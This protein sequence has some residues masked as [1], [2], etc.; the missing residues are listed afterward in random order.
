MSAPTYVGHGTIISQTGNA[1]NISVPVPSGYQQNDLLILTVETYDENVSTPSGWTLG[2]YVSYASQTRITLFYKWSAS[3]ESSVVVT[4]NMTDHVIGAMF[5]FRGVDTTSPFNA[6]QSSTANVSQYTN[7]TVQMP[8]STINDCLFAVFSSGSYD[9]ASDQSAFFTSI[10]ST[11]NLTNFTSSW[12][13]WRDKGNGGGLGISTGNLATA[14]S[15]GTL[16]VQRTLSEKI[17]NF[18]VALTPIS[19]TVAKNTF[20]GRCF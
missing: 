8:T 12:G 10:S 2:T 9:V 11:G 16:T 3:S 14:G 5:A 17:A 1:G 4:N 6:S 15:G 19:G 20:F 7:F 18:A 13:A